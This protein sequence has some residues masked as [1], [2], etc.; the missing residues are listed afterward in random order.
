ME[1]RQKVRGLGVTHED[2][3]V[4][5]A[6]LAENIERLDGNPKDL[7]RLARMAGN[8]IRLWRSVLRAEQILEKNGVEI[9]RSD[10]ES[11]TD[12]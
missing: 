3:S 7:K 1:E 5:E 8:T 2:L 6:E 10:D 9:V 12:V 11:D 4:L